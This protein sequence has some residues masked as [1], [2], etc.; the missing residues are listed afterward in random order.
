MR[1]CRVRRISPSIAIRPS[2][3][4]DPRLRFDLG[5]WTL[6][7]GPWTLV[8]RVR[9]RTLCQAST[10]ARFDLRPSTFVSSGRLG[11]FSS[12][13]LLRLHRTRFSRARPP[14]TGSKVEGRI[15]PKSSTVPPADK[16]VEEPRFKAQGP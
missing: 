15:R 13:G 6:D 8:R 10:S 3:Q 9:A 5:P 12:A 4:L 16:Q 11:K 7:L 2:A 14:E 1:G